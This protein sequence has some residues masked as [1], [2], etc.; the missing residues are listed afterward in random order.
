MRLRIST[1][2]WLPIVCYILLAFG[3]WYMYQNRT[4]YLIL[5]LESGV[6]TTPLL[7]LAVF[8]TAALQGKL[9]AALNILMGAVIIGIL[10]FLSYGKITDPQQ[11]LLANT[12]FHMALVLN[13]TLNVRI[14]SFKRRRAKKPWE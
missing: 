13:M 10:V 14:V 8:M 4:D 6:F 12:A 2:I 11:N 1:A 9:Q 3:H 7:T 5:S